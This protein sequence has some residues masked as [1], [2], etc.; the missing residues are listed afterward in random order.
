MRQQPSVLDEG[1]DMDHCKRAK[2]FREEFYR[3]MIRM[4]DGRT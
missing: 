2:D 4:Q 1:V 3:I